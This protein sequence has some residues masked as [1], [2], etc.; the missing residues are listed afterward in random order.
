MRIGIFSVYYICSHNGTVGLSA[1]A[2]YISRATGPVFTDGTKEFYRLD[3]SGGTAQRS[4]V[5]SRGPAK[6]PSHA[7][8][9]SRPVTL[10]GFSDPVIF[11]SL[12]PPLSPSSF[13]HLPSSSL[14]ARE[15]NQ[16][17]AAG[18]SPGVL[19]WQLAHRSH[20]LQGAGPRLTPQLVSSLVGLGLCVRACACVC[21]RVRACACVCVRVRACACVCACV[22]VCV[23]ACVRVCV[24]A[25]VRVCVCVCARVHACVRACV[26][27][28]VCGCSELLLRCGWKWC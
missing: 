26:C 2:P 6:L 9:Q 28:C 10:V 16:G 11:Y 12:P 3:W 23:C 5:E 27:V 1:H 7:H 18:S 24:C 14:P 25:C 19:P 17:G 21:V 4:L 13:S 8:C 20:S 22:R 15:A